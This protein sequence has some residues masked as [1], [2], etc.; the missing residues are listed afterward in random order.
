MPVKRCQKDNQQGYK[1]GDNGTCYI[2]YPDDEES[3]KE[4]KRKAIKQGV[5]AYSSGYEGDE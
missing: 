5:A 3:K 1:W 4:A 2:F